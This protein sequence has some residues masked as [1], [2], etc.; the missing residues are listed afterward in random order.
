MIAT[1]AWVLKVTIPHTYTTVGVQATSFTLKGT[2]NVVRGCLRP[3]SAL[4][5]Y[6]CPD[7]LFL[8]AEVLWD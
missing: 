3:D 2:Y 8:H 4:Q 7:Q 6:S 5:I 1:Q